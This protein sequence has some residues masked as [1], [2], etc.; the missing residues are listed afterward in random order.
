MDFC[1]SF[2]RDLLQLTMIEFAESL[3]TE[4]RDFFLGVE[5]Q[6]LETAMN[7]G[8]V[9]SESDAL[10]FEIFRFFA[11]RFE[12]FARLLMEF[13]LLLELVGQDLEVVSTERL[14]AFVVEFLARFFMTLLLLAMLP[15]LVLKIDEEIVDDLPRVG[16]LHFFGIC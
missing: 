13:L 3:Q 4:I 1:S 16:H 12:F 7:T 5:F 10:V 8:H 11:F 14:L 6:I 9:V 15:S 2:L